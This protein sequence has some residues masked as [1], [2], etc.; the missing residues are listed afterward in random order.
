MR[1]Y[2][3]SI[4]RQDLRLADRMLRLRLR[5]ITPKKYV[6]GNFLLGVLLWIPVGF[7][8]AYTKQNYGMSASLVLLGVVACILL[9]WKAAS[10]LSAKNIT[11]LQDKERKDNIRASIGISKSML[12]LT[13]DGGS[14]EMKRD[15]ISEVEKNSESCF[16]YI[17]P[18]FCYV[19]PKSGF[20]I[21]SEYDD[22]MQQLQDDT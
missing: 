6:V 5:R 11:K 19:I 13:M 9:S 8:W 2:T 15:E 17:G 18:L 14:V 16:I 4:S 20:A 10:Y 21:E 7:G 12:K 3:F 1:D 22:L